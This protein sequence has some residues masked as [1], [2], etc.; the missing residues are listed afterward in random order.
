MNIFSLFVIIVIISI[1]SNS[2]GKYLILEADNL[3]WDIHSEEITSK[4]VQAKYDYIFC[5]AKEVKISKGEVLSLSNG[6]LTTCNL[7]NNPHYKFSVKSLRLTPE[8]LIA[9]HLVFISPYMFI[10]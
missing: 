2:F 7:I 1:T 4:R 6:Y 9:K 5:K 8:K 10:I 3:I